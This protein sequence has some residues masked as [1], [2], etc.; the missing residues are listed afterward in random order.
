MN[1]QTQ[2]AP[3]TQEAKFLRASASPIEDIN[4]QSYEGQDPTLRL[5]HSGYEHF[6]QQIPILTPDDEFL[7]EKVA[8][9]RDVMQ[10]LGKVLNK[11]AWVEATNPGP[12]GFQRNILA[13]EP[14]KDL[15]LETH[16]DG[17]TSVVGGTQGSEIIVASWGDGFSSPVHG[18]APGFLHEEIL[19]GKVRVNTYR[20]IDPDSN[21]VRPIK[22]EMYSKGTFLSAYN[23]PHPEHPNP[24]RQAFVHNFTS[25]GFSATLHFIPEHTRDGRDNRFEVQHFESA[26][27]LSKLTRIT[28][29]EAMYLQKGEVVLVR[30]SNVPEYGDHFIVITGAPVVKEHGL[31]PEDVA[32]QAPH[33]AKILDEYD[34]FDGLVLLKLDKWSRMQFHEFH[35]IQIINGKVIFPQ[36]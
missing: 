34:S 3:P 16:M 7:D 29:K 35:G 4:R 33:A 12:G 10:H 27:G 18:H 9:A 8:L 31:R 2:V 20:M 32:I 26:V 1:T 23:Y 13:I 6:F 22:T 36:P 17:K 30:S 24:P 19:T 28:S 21:V 15:T 5:Y 14:A 25:I 11:S